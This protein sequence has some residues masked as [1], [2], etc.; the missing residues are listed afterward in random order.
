MRVRFPL[1]PVECKLI[2][3]V[4]FETFLNFAAVHF[5]GSNVLVYARISA[6][7]FFHPESDVAALPHNDDSL[8]FIAE[9]IKRISVS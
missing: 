4:G 5:S 7:M 2:R 6:P 1:K 9:Q 8:F 3:R